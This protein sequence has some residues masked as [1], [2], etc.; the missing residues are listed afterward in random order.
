MKQTIIS[1]LALAALLLVPGRGESCTNLLISKGATKD[2]S[3]MVTYSA[4]SHQ[5]YGELYFK[6]ANSFAPGSMLKIYEWDSGKYLGEIPQIGKTYTTVGNMN[7]HQVIITETTFGGL[8]LEDST[9][10]MDY[11]SLIY[12]TLQRAK[13]AREAIKIMTDFV[14]E[15]G[16]YSAGESFS[17]A[18]KNE[19]WILEMIGKGVKMVNGKNANRGAVWVAARIPD[20]YISAHAN[21]ARITTFP[22]NDPENFLY[23]PDVISFARENGYYK[24]TDKDFSFSDTYAPLD[25]GSMRGCEAR[26]WAAFN[27][28]GG[29]MIN[30]KP[31]TDYED[32]AMGHNAKNRLPLY[33]KPAQK[34]TVKMVA[35]VM[36]DHYEGTALDMTKDAGA[37]GHALP[38]RWRPMGFKVDGVS[39]TNERAIA[40]QQTGFWLLG[41]ARNWLPDEVGGIFWFGVDDAATSA[42]TPIYSSSLRVPECFRVGNGDMLTYSPTSA[43]W[44]FNRVTNFAYL[45]YD[46]VAPEIRK[47]GDKHEIDA[48]ERTAAI[49]EAAMM[50]YKESPQKAREFLTDYSVNTAQELFAKWDKLD[51]YLLVKFMDGNIKK[52]DANG[53]FIDNG[54]GK[55]I[56]PM[57]SQPGYSE[58][59]K[60]TVKESAGERLMAK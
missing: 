58:M 16:Y 22:L 6:M 59:W 46:R 12:V 3:V 45:L 17:I 49:D 5:L 31:Y 13:T 11:G 26:V 30:G 60:R 43:F 37:G 14:K 8:P 28:L 42:L 24:G 29:G 23:A 9:A 54:Y 10:I 47:V 55:N 19:V 4:D 2:G 38:Y 27:I 7:E 18:D 48:I 52:Q 1:F 57:P 32:Y 25:F 51:K 21:H 53:C 50:L 39:Y 41:Q 15:Y 35:D 56:P 34:L 40:T 33:I 36:R 44:L 20:G